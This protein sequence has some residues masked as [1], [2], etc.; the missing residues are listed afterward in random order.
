MAPREHV[1]IGKEEPTR[2]EQEST[3]AGY[4]F[5]GFRLEADGTLLHG[6]K[7]IHLPPKEL[8]ALRLLL[9]RAG[10][11]VTPTELREELWGEVHV[12]ADS[13]PK[14]LSSLRA[15]L[16]PEDCIQTVYKRGYRL[17]AD[18][19]PFVAAAT[20]SL[21]RLALMPFEISFGFPEHIGLA[22]VEETIDRLVNLKPALVQ[23]IA[24]DSV[25]TLA[26][27]ERTAQQLGEE[28]K[29][30]LVLTG[31]LRALPTH[32]RLRARMIR[33]ND[34]TEIWVEDLLSDRSRVGG[35]E[36]ELVV[37]LKN[38]LAPS[39]VS[40]SAAS[41]PEPDPSPESTP[42]RRE[43]HE[44]FLRGRYELQTL[45]R[46][47]MQD[48]LQHLLRAT[49]LD[50]TLTS[51]Q[52]EL[53]NLC[54]TQAFYGFMSP[55]VAADNVRR[56][57][58]AIPDDSHA[59]EQVLPSLGWIR[60]HVDRNLPA[61]IEA[62]ERSSHLPNDPWVLRLRVMFE[63]SRRRFSE[64]EALLESALL[65]DPYSP[66]LLARLAWTHFLS[67][68]NEQSRERIHRALSMFPMHPAP[69]LYGAVILSYLGETAR[70]LQI[71]SEYAQRHPYVDLAAIVHAYALVSVGKPDD[72]RT[73]LD[74]LHWLS[75]E[76]FVQSSFTPAVYV[77]LGDHQAAL[78]ELKN[79]ESNRC[80]W[81]FQMLADPRL[82]PLAEHPEMK[83]MQQILAHMESACVA[84]EGR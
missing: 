43:A 55:A 25:F 41:D 56:A 68:R 28:L 66:W 44:I 79:A 14:C 33:V 31:S 46:H 4:A 65:E 69:C 50:P 53:A 1:L 45:E 40:I 84:L 67:G 3:E 52:I 76:R 21:P 2:A 27:T 49:E 47:R 83:R 51:A 81:F 80:P 64:A 19:Q 16:A 37:R 54:C 36:S 18:V 9:A 60:F 8:A 30:D 78:A 6:R 59:A 29:A 15:R 32:F 38:R 57:A 24:R 82:K 23:V 75:R 26:R 73:I 34:G 11:I 58:G 70:A 61:A 12:T 22:V 48:G 74:R 62:F 72:A 5:A 35:L 20:S 77:A 13:V 63:L 17:S 7:V 39:G 71:A 42:N 10:Q